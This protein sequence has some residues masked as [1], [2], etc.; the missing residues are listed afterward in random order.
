MPLTCTCSTKFVVACPV[1]AATEACCQRAAEHG[2]TSR[3]T[4]AGFEGGA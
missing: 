3:M 1:N 2:I 4:R